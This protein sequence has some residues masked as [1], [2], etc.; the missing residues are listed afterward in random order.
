[1]LCKN[2]TVKIYLLKFRIGRLEEKKYKS[3]QNLAESNP[4]RFSRTDFF[5]N[6]FPEIFVPLDKEIA[7]ATRLI[8]ILKNQN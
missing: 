5:E 8:K 1:M 6:S 3:L 2:K 7:K 4:E